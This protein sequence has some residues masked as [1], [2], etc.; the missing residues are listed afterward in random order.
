MIPGIHIKWRLASEQP[1]SFPSLIKLIFKKMNSSVN[2]TKITFFIA[3]ICLVMLS[4]LHAQVITFEPGSIGMAN[5]S[6]GLVVSNQYANIGCGVTFFLGDPNAAVPQRPVIAQVGKQGG[7]ANAFFGPSNT[8]CGS[9]PA[10]VGDMPDATANTGCFFLT[11]DTDPW[12]FPAETLSVV[13]SSPSQAAEGDILD[14]DGDEEWVINAYDNGTLVHTVTIGPFPISGPQNG[15]ANHWIM[16]PPGSVTFDMLMLIQI[17]DGTDG[18]GWALD[19]FDPCATYLW[20]NYCCEGTNLVKYGNFESGNTGFSSDYSYEGTISGTSLSPGEYSVV[21]GGQASTLRSIWDVVDHGSC[22]YFS[23]F[24]VVDGMTQQSGSKEIYKTSVGLDKD[25]EYR[26]CA[27]FKNLPT[28]AF[29]IEPT[30]T[31]HVSGSPPFTQTISAGSGACDWVEVSFP[32]ATTLANTSIA[33]FLD[34]T[35]NG[36]GND[37][38]ID[39][40]SIQEIEEVPFAWVDFNLDMVET[41]PSTFELTASYPGYPNPENCFSWWSVCELDETLTCIP[42]TEVINPPAWWTYPTPHSFEGYVGTSTLIGTSPGVFQLGRS[43]KIT[44]GAWCD[45]MGWNEKSM[46]Y[47]PEEGISQPAPEDRPKFELREDQIQ[48]AMRSLMEGS[49]KTHE[50]ETH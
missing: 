5:P 1:S 31:I 14:V 3:F 48:E 34:E 29:D 46:I 40:I 23:E 20:E 4:S 22:S 16:N 36:D 45:C 39:D 12:N 32:L 47:I 33:I 49:S 30:V 2:H 50:Q 13:Y 41:G 7:S 27:Y 38:A 10:T 37:L 26:F 28:C 42:G 15:M 17:G 9:S 6:E 19:N 43:Y 21:T 18:I 35:G 44:Y 25:K 24:M 11:D 8:F